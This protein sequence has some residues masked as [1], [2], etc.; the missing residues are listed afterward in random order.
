MARRKRSHTNQEELS[1]TQIA[2]PDNKSGSLLANK[3][4]AILFFIFVFLFVIGITFIVLKVLKV[5]V[6]FI[7]FPERVSSSGWVNPNIKEIN[8]IRQQMA[9]YFINT[10]QDLGGQAGK[11]VWFVT[12]VRSLELKDQWSKTGWPPQNRNSPSEDE[13][14][15]IYAEIDAV[16]KTSSVIIEGNWA[17]WIPEQSVP[18]P[19]QYTFRG[20]PGLVLYKIDKTWYIF[21]GSDAEIKAYG[22]PPIKVIPLDA[23][24]PLLERYSIDQKSGQ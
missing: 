10:M 20:Y 15:R 17:R 1:A 5:S 24:K 3:L 8:S 2:K 9:A 13:V 6:P 12:P 23:S 4:P 21:G 11:V 22:N 18:T 7:T 19:Y 16:V 14:K